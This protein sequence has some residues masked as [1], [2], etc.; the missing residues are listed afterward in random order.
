MTRRR[1]TL[2]DARRRLV[3]AQAKRTEARAA[4]E[5]GGLV[6][7]VDVEQRW[8]RIVL[9]ARNRLLGIPSRLKQRRSTLT[10]ADL[11]EVDA[12]IREVLEELAS[13]VS[14]AREASPVPDD[15]E[16]A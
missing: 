15:P 4:K 16:T 8:T 12:L 7:A 11:R 9:T 5:A 6:S 14:A 13:G 3:S 1:P 10:A 2:A